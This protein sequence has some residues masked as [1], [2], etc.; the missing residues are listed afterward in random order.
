MYKII[1]FTHGELSNSLKKTAELISGPNPNVEFYGI[2]LGCDTGEVLDQVK[3]SLRDSKIRNVDTLIFTDLFY[4]TPFNLLMSIV[5]S[6]Q[7]SHVTGVNLPMLLEAIVLQDQKE[8]NFCN[9]V[10]DLVAKGRE[11][12][13]DCDKFVQDL[14]NRKE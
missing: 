7:F 10:S 13:V 14:L 3:A 12:I 8:I 5:N 2:P 4:G 9:I 11:S 6:N 1:V